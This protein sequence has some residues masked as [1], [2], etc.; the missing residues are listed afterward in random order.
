MPKIILFLLIG[1]FF[2]FLILSIAPSVV[3]AQSLVDAS[4]V[5]CRKD[6]TCELNDI[7]KIVVAGTNIIFGIIGTVV[8]VMF[9]YGGFTFM[10]SAGSKERVTK[11][12]TIIIQS[13]IGM[14]I[15][16]LSYTIVGFVFAMLGIS[17]NF[18]S[19]GWFT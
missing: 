9:I 2:S 11:G 18:Y 7:W 13:I 16:F 12:K 6:G 8:L 4:S 15:M 14:A 5:D 19:T 17:G 1:I 3:S 10:T